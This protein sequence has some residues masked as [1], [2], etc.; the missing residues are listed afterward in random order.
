MGYKN[1]SLKSFFI[2]FFFVLVFGIVGSMFLKDYK[3]KKYPEKFVDESV[4]VERN[5]NA[6][7]QI[8]NVPSRSVELGDEFTF[9]PRIIPSENDAKLNLLNGPDWM[10]FDGTIV[11][12]IPKEVETVSFILRLEQGGEYVDREFYLVVTENTD[13]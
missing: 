1:R 9:N 12:G 4:A 6:F 3:Q 13:E 8:I 2:T 11:S 7:P 5:Y 10:S